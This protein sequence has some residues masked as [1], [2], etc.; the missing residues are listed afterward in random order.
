[1]IS[2]YSNIPVKFASQLSSRK[3]MKKSGF[4]SF[5]NYWYSQQIKRDNLS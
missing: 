2:S 5:S 3:I 1:M 4:N